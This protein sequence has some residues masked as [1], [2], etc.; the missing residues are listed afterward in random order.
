MN[1]KERANVNIIAKIS[2]ARSDDLGT[3]IMTVLAHLGHKHA[4]AAT[5]SLGKTINA[6]KNTFD[7]ID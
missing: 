6:V 2:K 4:R 7:L 1:L 5:F 3:S